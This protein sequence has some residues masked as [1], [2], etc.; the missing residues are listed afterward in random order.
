MN[1]QKYLE[2]KSLSIVLFL[3]L[4]VLYAVIYMTKS[5]FS[6]AMASI[7]EKGFMTASQTGLINAAF[8]LVYAIFQVV[9]GFCAD[10]FSSYKIIMIGLFGSLIA[11]T[12][13][14]FNQDYY[15]MIG[16]WVFNA[17]AQFGIWPGVFKIITTQLKPDLRGKA[18]FWMLFAGSL[19]LGISMLV[20]SFV[21]HWKNNFLVSIISSILLIVGY[22][23]IHHITDRKMVTAEPVLKEQ[24]ALVEKAKT[25][26]LMMS[27]GLIVLLFVCFLRVAVDNGIK[28]LTPTMLMQSYNN[29]SAAVSNRIS[30]ILVISSALGIFV[31]RFVQKKITHNE[32]KAQF[33]IYT[34]SLLPLIAACFVGKIHYVFILVALSAVVLL[35]GGASPFSQSF[36]SVRFEKYGRIGTVSGILNAGASVGNIFASYVFAKMADVM[37]WEGVAFSWIGA[38]FLCAVLCIAVLRRWS[39]FLTE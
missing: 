15:V 7:V 27:S 18:V 38:D 29:L 28:M 5:M 21:S 13:I 23:V 25:F 35:S 1:R 9:G 30:S 34:T 20:A 10:K 2:S 8:W 24:G 17:M 22:I 14:Y 19:G 37:S 6:S 12:V 11:N 39:K 26:P 31:A 4:F 36:I 33:L 16:A 3:F 32:A